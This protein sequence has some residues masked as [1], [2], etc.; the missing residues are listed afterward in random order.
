[1]RKK[2]EDGKAYSDTFLQNIVVNFNL[3]GRH[4]SSVAMSFFFWLIIHNPQ[5]EDKVIG[6][7]FEVLT[8][9]RG[10]DPS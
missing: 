4:T 5:V 3:S 8:K 1:M 9:S 6:E 7:I 10:T 2:N